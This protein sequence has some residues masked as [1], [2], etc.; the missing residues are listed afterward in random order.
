M[1]ALRRRMRVEVVTNEG[2]MLQTRHP[3][4]D[5]FLEGL[6]LIQ[7]SKGSIGRALERSFRP[8]TGRPALIVV[9]TPDLRREDVRAIALRS[10][11][12]AAGAIVWIDAGSFEPGANGRRRR[13]PHGHSLVLPFP[14][15]PL[16]AGDSFRAVW[17]TTIKDVALAR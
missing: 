13:A 6:A 16:H 17:H 15:L 14:V 2:P 7:P 3:T 8:R 12:S 11:N 1:L 10:K 9:I 4:K 5:Q